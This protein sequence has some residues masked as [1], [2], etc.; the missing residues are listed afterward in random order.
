MH[1]QSNNPSSWHQF[2][3]VPYPKEGVYYAV[4]K[5]KNVKWGRDSISRPV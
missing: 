1:T 3:M 5:S 4:P 2:D